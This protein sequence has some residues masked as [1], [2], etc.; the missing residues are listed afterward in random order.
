MHVWGWQEIIESKEAALL[1]TLTQVHQHTH[2]I[3]THTQIIIE[4]A[5]KQH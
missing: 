5:R 3:I 1:N 2:I 4:R